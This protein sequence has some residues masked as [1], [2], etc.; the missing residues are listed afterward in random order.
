MEDAYDDSLTIGFLPHSVEKCGYTDL[1]R[2]FGQDFGASG[3]FVD[4]S[5]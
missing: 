4:S 3:S 2:G 1:P 5:T